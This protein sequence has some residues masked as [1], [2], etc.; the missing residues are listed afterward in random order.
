MLGDDHPR[1][2]LRILLDEIAALEPEPIEIGEE[3]ETKFELPALRVGTASPSERPSVLLKEVDAKKIRMLREEVQI[4]AYARF[5]HLHR[6]VAELEE[7]TRGGEEGMSSIFLKRGEELK[8]TLEDAIER[9]ERD[10][11]GGRDVLH[12]RA[13]KTRIGEDRLRGFEDQLTISL[14]LLGVLIHSSVHLRPV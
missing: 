10:A 4:A 1:H 11:R 9:I 8:L 12:L 14:A 2:K 6:I 3:P 7:R 5:E 13:I